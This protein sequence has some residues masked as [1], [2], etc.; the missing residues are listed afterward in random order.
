LSGLFVEAPVLVPVLDLYQHQL[1]I[2]GVSV[3]A[4]CNSYAMGYGISIPFDRLALHEHRPWVEDLARL[5]YTDAWSSEAAGTDAFTP[6]ALAAAWDSQLRLGTAIVPTFTRGPALLAMTAAAMAETAPG[7][8]VLGIGTSSDV[9][10]RLWNGMPFEEPYRRTRDVIRFL[11]AALAGEKVSGDFDTFSV[12]GF[13][14]ERPVVQPPQIMVAALRPG[15]L[16]LAGREG[17]GAVIN[18][19][20][21]QDVARVVPEVGEGKEIVARIFVCPTEDSDLVRAKGRRLVAAYLTV[22]VYAAF[23]RWLGRGPLLEGLWKAWS[24][25]DRVGAAA[26]VPDE[27][28]DDLIVHGSANRCRAQIQRYV[29]NGVTTPVLALLPWGVDLRQAITD[30]APQL[31]SGGGTMRA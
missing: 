7:R 28:I 8:F 21:A 15:M 30:L 3:A 17:D 10:V 24:A 22:G 11:R 16:H 23:H 6:L 13:R 18:W 4:G 5:G 2:H 29:D 19:L 31:P 26:S 14:L 9:I 12:R 25:G 27:V 1:A 20:S